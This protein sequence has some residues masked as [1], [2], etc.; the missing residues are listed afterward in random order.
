MA[1]EVL[2]ARVRAFVSALRGFLRGFIG[3]TSVGRDA[4]SVQCA[5]AHRAEGRRGCC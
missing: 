1:A 3:A 4:R 2:V 5:L